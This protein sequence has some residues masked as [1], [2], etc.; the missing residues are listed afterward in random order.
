MKIIITGASGLIGSFLAQ[1]FAEDHNQVIS[2]DLK[3]GHDL[4]DEI[5]VKEFFC[6]CKADAVIICHAIDDKIELKR[7]ESNIMNIEI[8]S[9]A[10]MFDINVLSAFSVAREYVRNNPKGSVL[11]FSSI[12]GERSPRHK[13]YGESKKSIGYGISKAAIINMTKY[14]AAYCAPNFR[15]NCLVPG[16][17][18]ANETVEFRENYSTLVPLGRM[19]N[20]A[21][22]YGI[23]NYLTS[24][25]SSYV[26]GGIY[27]IDGGYLSC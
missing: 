6:K 24:E 8:A 10:K 16:G 11:F 20:V 17:I 22:I 21:E 25:S 13:I 7:V 2:L 5:F 9:I 26:T 18:T 3:L 14:L 4:T 12:Y 27:S 1:K 19:M 15:F 23:V